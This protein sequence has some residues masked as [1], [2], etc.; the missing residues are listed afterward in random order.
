MKRNVPKSRLQVRAL[1][2]GAIMV[3]LAQILS[4]IKLFGNL[5]NGGSITFAMFPLLLF[6]VR[7]GLGRG[8]MAGFTFGLLQLI[9]D[10]AY[11]WGWQSMLLDYLVAFTPLG[12]AGLFKGKS[13]GIF[14]GTVLGCVAR[15]AVHYIS[16]VTIYRIYQPAEIPGIGVFDDAVLYSLVYNGAY[17]LPNMLLA[18]AVAG[19][20]Y[21]P[22]KRYF[23]GTDLLR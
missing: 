13:W 19:V 21:V 9:F 18:L 10:G 17:M 1:C 7:F 5:P 11:A 8:L 3:A 6:A 15:F 23:A 12:L 20:L 2:E 22:M 4:Y 14:P 16:G